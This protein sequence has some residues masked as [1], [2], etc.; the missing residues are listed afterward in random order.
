MKNT[1][2]IFLKSN[3]PVS[4][5]VLKY[6]RD[7]DELIKT[8]GH[9]KSILLLN[10]PGDHVSM[11]SVSSLKENPEMWISRQEQ[12]LWNQLQLQFL[13]GCWW[14]IIAKNYS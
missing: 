4:P 5:L 8:D 7:E 6:I 12:H 11:L 3:S 2:Y 13:I 9:N 1:H 10:Y 14:A